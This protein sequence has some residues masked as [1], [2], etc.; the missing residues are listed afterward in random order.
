MINLSKAKASRILL[1]LCLHSVV[2]CFELT[3]DNSDVSGVVLATSD[4]RTVTCDDGYAIDDG[5]GATSF[6]VSCDAGSGGTVSISGVDTCDGMCATCSLFWML[7]LSCVVQLWHA[8][9]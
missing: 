2:A 5:S 3:V 4:T 1:A 6:A 9:P 7:I 8:M